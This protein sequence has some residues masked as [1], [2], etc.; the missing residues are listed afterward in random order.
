MFGAS[1]AAVAGIVADRDVAPGQL[2]ELGVQ[3][4]LVPFDRQD[5]VGAASGEVVGMA[6]L[7]VHRVR[8]DDRTG[9]VDTVQKR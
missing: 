7:G 9:E 2:L 8:C 6:A 3:V 5:V 1:V 4:R